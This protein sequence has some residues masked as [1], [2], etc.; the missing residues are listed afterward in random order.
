MIEP[1]PHRWRSIQ[2]T[3]GDIVEVPT[4]AE[5]VSL[6]PAAD[7]SGEVTV[8]FFV[9]DLIGEFDRVP[10]TESR[11]IESETIGRDETSRTVFRHHSTI[12][13]ASDGESARVYYLGQTEEERRLL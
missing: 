13:P 3:V 7:G 5:S 6:L 2:G 4:D 1:V 12:V 11:P 9:F 8:S 10:E